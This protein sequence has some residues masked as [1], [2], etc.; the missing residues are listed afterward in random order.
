MRKK[1]KVIAAVDIMDGS[2]VRLIKGDPSNKITY[3]NNPIEIARRWETAGADLLHIVDLDAAL[4]NGNNNSNLISKIVSSVTIPVE[5]AGGIRAYETAEDILTK[6]SKVVIGTIA[7]RD[8]EIIRKLVKKN[9][10]DRIVISIDQ[11]GGMVMVKGWKESTDVKVLDAI[12]KFRAMGIEEFLLTSVERDGTLE[13]PDLQSLSEAVVSGGKIIASGGISSI[14]DVIKV[15][16]LGC[17]SVILGKAM[18]DGKLTIERAK[19][20][21]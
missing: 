17:S 12:S 2:V 7:Y 15:K 9:G 13:G 8:P 3:S 20:V 11:R 5:V 6:A 14:E 10:K 21:A 4:S 18:Y 16:N 19:M 1:M